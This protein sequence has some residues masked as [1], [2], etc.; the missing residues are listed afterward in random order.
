[1]QLLFLAEI[2]TQSFGGWDFAKTPL[3]EFTAL[4]QTPIA[5]FRGPTSKRK[6]GG[7]REGRKEGKEGY[8]QEGRRKK[9]RKGAYLD[10]A[11]KLKS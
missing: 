3:G 10:D 8:G 7:K 2:S 6:K 9:G 5:V 11:P 4:L 1:M